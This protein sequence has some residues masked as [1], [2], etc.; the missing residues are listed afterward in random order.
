MIKLGGVP[1]HL[2]SLQLET[3]LVGKLWSEKYPLTVC[4]IDRSLL[5][6]KI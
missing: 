3:Q 2:N 5:T 4:R 6:I 1:V